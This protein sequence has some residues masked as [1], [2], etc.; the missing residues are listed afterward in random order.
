MDD[1]DTLDPMPPAAAPDTTPP[2]QAARV[3]PWFGSATAPTKV[4]TPEKYHGER[5]IIT[6][7]NWLF[8][9][10]RYM[11]LTGMP[12]YKQV[13]YASTL[14]HGE[15][16][17]WY[18]SNYKSTDPTSLAWADVRRELHAYFAPPNQDRRLNDEW[19][20]LRQEGTVY[21]YVSK[22][23]ALAMQMTGLTDTSKLDKF[24]C[25]LKPK[26]RIE[27][28][29]R[30]PKTPDEA[31]RLADR[32]DCIVYGYKDTFLP[33]T[34]TELNQHNSLSIWED[35]RGEPMQID[36][37][38]VRNPRAVMFSAARPGPCRN[39]NPKDSDRAKG[40]CFNCHKPGHL[41]RECCST[42]PLAKAYDMVKIPFS[43][44]NTPRKFQQN[45]SGNG[46]TRP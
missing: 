44:R 25:G 24:I 43:T 6:L 20:Q 18:R 1:F 13:M 14:L 32:F 8:T 28:E 9:M 35:N 19:A 37:L 38:S 7:G 26:T 40:L 30:D 39:N 15:A 34:S 12:P 3:P 2:F 42:N 41:A 22:L 23:Q 16:M 4:P 36:S 11:T 46:H 10:D 17:L 21:N 45:S 33:S 5:N 31:Y 27:V 29:L